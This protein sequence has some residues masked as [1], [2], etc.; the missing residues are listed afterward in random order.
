M[1]RRAI[2]IAL[3]ALS[4]CGSEPAATDGR[5]DRAVTPQPSGP[6]VVQQVE[7]ANPPRSGAEADRGG[8]S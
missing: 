7:G 4:A 8:A 1:T 2:A 5:G 6:P 3:L